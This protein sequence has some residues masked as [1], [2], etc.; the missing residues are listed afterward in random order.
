MSEDG[1]SPLPADL[2]DVLVKVRTNVVLGYETPRGIRAR[3]DC[4]EEQ[5]SDDDEDN[6]EMT[7][8]ERCVGGR[9]C[10]GRN[11]RRDG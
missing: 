5:G 3:E 7:R 9:S 10:A 2:L 4:E 1:A 11:S 6:E 8:R